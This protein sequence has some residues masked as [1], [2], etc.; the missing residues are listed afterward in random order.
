MDSAKET[1]EKLRGPARALR[2]E[3]PDVFR[4]YGELSRAA[5]ADGELSDLTKEFAA[6]A[7]AIV[8][9]CDGCIVAHVRNLV[10][11]GATR[12]QV[13]ELCGVAIMMD[14]GPGTVWGP[15]SL[16]AYDELV[17]ERSTDGSSL[18]K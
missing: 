11:L 13:A 9:Q 10:R 18:N 3:I 15:R 6:L 4:A 5:M 8:K 1:Q 12:H 2:D 14:G 16:A 17:A 7:I